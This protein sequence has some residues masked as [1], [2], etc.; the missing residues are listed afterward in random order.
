M[1]YSTVRLKVGT[2]SEGQFTIPRG[3]RGIVRDPFQEQRF[4]PQSLVDV[5]VD[6]NGTNVYMNL[7]HISKICPVVTTDIR[8]INPPHVSVIVSA[9]LDTLSIT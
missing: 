2:L 1:V 6:F 3:L 7:G 5:D 4:E 9:L 8:K